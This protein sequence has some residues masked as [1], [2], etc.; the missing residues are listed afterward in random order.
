LNA[1]VAR[2]LVDAILDPAAMGALRKTIAHALT[3]IQ[4][5]DANLS[6]SLRP[7]TPP[8]TTEIRDARGLTAGEETRVTNTV[9][10]HVNANDITVAPIKPPEPGLGGITFGR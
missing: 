7:G 10:T 9:T 2:C 6:H 4:H 5:G 8:G 3:G 1:T